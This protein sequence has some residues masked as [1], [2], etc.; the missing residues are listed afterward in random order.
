MGHVPW[1]S[2]PSERHRLGH[3]RQS[4]G[5]S[6]MRKGVLG[7]DE[8]SHDAVDPHLRSPLHRKRGSQVRQSGFRCPVGGRAGEGR[9]P[10]TLPI[11]RITPPST[12]SCMTLL[13]A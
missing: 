1:G 13:A 6:V 4:F 7:L 11:I 3:S 12:W 5:A 8:P 10:E 9:V 2:Q